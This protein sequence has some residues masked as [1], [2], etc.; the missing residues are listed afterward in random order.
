MPKTAVKKVVRRIRTPKT[1]KP[2]VSKKVIRK[3]NRKRP[4]S[5]LEKAIHSI[6]KEEKIPFTKEK[7]IGRCHA[8]IFIEPRTVVELA[9]CYWHG[10]SCQKKPFSEMQLKAQASD[11]RRFA[12]FKKLGFSVYVIWEHE[13]EKDPESVRVRLRGIFDQ[14]KA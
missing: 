14:A 13:L 7:T 12:F 2:R 10:C 4:A 9:G 1:G 11:A 8:D 5:G 6:L 3:A